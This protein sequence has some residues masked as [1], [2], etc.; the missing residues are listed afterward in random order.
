VSTE[1]YIQTT[2]DAE[3]WE[4]VDQYTWDNR[5]KALREHEGAYLPRYTENRFLVDSGEVTI[6][7]EN[8]SSKEVFI[9][10]K[11]AGYDVRHAPNATHPGGFGQE[12]E[13]IRFQGRGESH[14][15][16]HLPSGDSFKQTVQ[17]K[18][19]IAA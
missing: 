5:T 19:K 6:T 12:P 3:V 11:L 4:Q 8:L 7:A 13:Y 16:R 18:P 9:I 10:A 17:K 15:V 1:R 2:E 14:I